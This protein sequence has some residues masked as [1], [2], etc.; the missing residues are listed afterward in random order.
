MNDLISF[1]MKIVNFESQACWKHTNVASWSCGC[2]TYCKCSCYPKGCHLELSHL[3]F[4]QLSL[5]L[6]SSCFYCSHHRKTDHHHAIDC[7]GD[8]P[9]YQKSVKELW[10]TETSLNLNHNLLHS[11]E[12]VLLQ[13]ETNHS[14]HR[15]SF[16]L[17]KSKFW[18]LATLES[19]EGNDS[20]GAWRLHSIRIITNQTSGQFLI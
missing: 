18:V 11:L 6:F 14:I 9:L 2:S 3:Q 19:W 20:L 17:T 4:P 5:W 7:V 1:N 8:H 12:I 10:V 13:W 15:G 16:K